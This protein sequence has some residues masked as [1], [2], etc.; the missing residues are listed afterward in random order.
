MGEGGCA[1]GRVVAVDA[2]HTI[3]VESLG[4]SAPVVI[5]VLRPG[6]WIADLLEASVAVIGVIDEASGHVGLGEE[7]SSCIVG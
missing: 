4:D 3:A 6:G 7:S 1:T 5:G 2:L